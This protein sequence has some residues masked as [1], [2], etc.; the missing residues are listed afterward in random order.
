[1]VSETTKV[2]NQPPSN[3]S[4]IRATMLRAGDIVEMSFELL[5]L[6]AQL[7]TQ[8]AATAKSRVKPALIAVILAF[9]LL[10]SGLPV[11][12]F[13]LASGLSQWAHFPVWMAQILMSV[14][15]LTTGAILLS[16][17]WRTL[18]KASNAFETSRIEASENLKWFRRTIQDSLR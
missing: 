10:L 14:I 6:Q 17:A 7:V 1:M 16:Y 8:D 9:G 13:G 3:G 4:P 5:S 15:Y 12:A 18:S 11:L 2:G